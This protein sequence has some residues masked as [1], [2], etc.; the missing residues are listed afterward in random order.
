MF[1]CP[2][3]GQRRTVVFNFVFCVTIYGLLAGRRSVGPLRHQ[4][5]V[6]GPNL[7]YLFARL[8]LVFA[9]KTSL[10]VEVKS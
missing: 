5:K 10:S 8:P 2:G 1:Y 7:T 9:E 3:R 4:W 6:N